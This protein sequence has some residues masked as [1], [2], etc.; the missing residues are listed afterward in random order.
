MELTKQDTKM[1]KGLAIIFMV[2]LHLFCRKTDVPY[3]CIKLAGGIPLVYYIGLMGDCCVA[4]YCFCSGYALEIINQKQLSTSDYYLGRLKSILKLMINFWIILVLFS[5]VGLIT[6]NEIIP[7]S[8]KSFVLNVLLIDKYNGAWWF[9]FTYIL[10]VVISRPIYVAVKRMN[11]I[12][13]L[14]IS[15][16]IYFIA[17]LQRIKVIVHFDIVALDWIMSQLALLGT[18]LMPFVWGML[19]Y[20]YRFFT[21]LKTNLYKK[22]KDKQIVFFGII[23]FFIIMIFHGLFQSLIVAP[24]TG[25]CVLII[26]NIVKKSDF[27]NRTFEF[28]GEHSTNIWLIHMFFYSVLFKDFIFIAKY[29]LLIF[30]FM[31]LLTISCS[32]IINIIYK[33]L[34]K[35]IR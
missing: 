34:V 10:L 31:M 15:I 4:I 12:L 25:L 35:L 30:A 22:I 8:L 32:Y 29:P 33:P 13:I 9:L 16:F 11:P 5:V 2:I 7:G 18:S 24:F 21:S 1:T 27:V 6:H 19:F 3:S 28:L 14:V 20:K 23:I 26:F 17:Y